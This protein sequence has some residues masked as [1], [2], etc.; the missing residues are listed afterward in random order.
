MPDYSIVIP[1][2]NERARL[3][4]TLRAVL[5]HLRAARPDAEVIVVDDGSGD[6]TADWVRSQSSPDIP[7]QVISYRPNRGKGH[8]VK[9]GMLAARGKYVLFMDADGATGIEEAEKMWPWLESGRA[10]VVI[11]SRALSSSRIEKSQSPI[12][13]LAG[14]LFGVLSRLLVLRGIMDTQ[15]GFKAFTRPAAQSIFSSQTIVSAIFDIEV[16]VL[17]AKRQLRVCELPVIWRHD[18][19]TRIA[20]NWHKC[21]RVFLELLKLKVRHRILWPLSLETLHPAGGTP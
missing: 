10:D 16:L 9:T 1:C 13:R 21:M 4:A 17:A 3:P 19:D 7:V 15:C 6:G 12:R 14:D 8:A 2:Y 18:N 20:Y 5:A 11:G